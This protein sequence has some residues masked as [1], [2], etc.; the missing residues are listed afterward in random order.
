MDKGAC[1]VLL[2]VLDLPGIRGGDRA[3]LINENDILAGKMIAVKKVVVVG[4]DWLQNSRPDSR[5][6][7][8]Y[9]DY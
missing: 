1:G 6:R 5:T 4:C 9:I 2:T 3:I 8:E 7:N